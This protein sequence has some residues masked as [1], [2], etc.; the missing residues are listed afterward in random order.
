MPGKLRISRYPIHVVQEAYLAQK[1][2]FG[3]ADRRDI[4]AVKAT[5]RDKKA[6]INRPT[7]LKGKKPGRTGRDKGLQ[8]DGND[9]D[10]EQADHEGGHADGDADAEADVTYLATRATGALS[11]AGRSATPHHHDECSTNE[12]FSEKPE[13]GMQK[14][15]RK[16]PGTTPVLASDS[17]REQ[18]KGQPGSS[19]TQSDEW[20]LVAIDSDSEAEDSE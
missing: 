16:T 12:A 17:E 19:D 5:L 13:A 4:N 2:G 9:K 11:I 8:W 7:R 15:S 14:E 6:E 20:D 1:R 3:F 18:W 10:Q